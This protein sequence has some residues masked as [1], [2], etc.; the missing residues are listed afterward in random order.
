MAARR[1]GQRAGGRAQSLRRD[2][3]AAPVAAFD[4]RIAPAGPRHGPCRR[5]GARDPRQRASRPIPAE[6]PIAMAETP[7]PSSPPDASPKPPMHA[8]WL[9]RWILPIAALATLVW[10]WKLG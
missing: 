4:S 3:A 6:P 7:K 10:G 2:A 1:A 9:R 8:A 5:Y